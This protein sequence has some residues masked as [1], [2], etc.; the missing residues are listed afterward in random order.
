MSL[1]NDLKF[2]KKIIRNIKKIQ[3]TKQYKNNFIG[4]NEYCS[5]G[6]L[7]YN[8]S[9]D[10]VSYFYNGNECT[11]LDDEDG[12]INIKF[13]EYD[14]ST[15]EGY[16]QLSLLYTENQ[17]KALVLFNAIRKTFNYSFSIPFDLLGNFDD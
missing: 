14:V 15:E 2:S 1:E 8:P 12:Y 11:P 7:C 16:F 3:K 5:I 4:D 9:C 10:F 17:V 6:Y 13:S